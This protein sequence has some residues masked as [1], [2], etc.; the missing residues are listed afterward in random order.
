MA[1]GMVTQMRPTM[2]RM[3]LR[4]RVMVLLS[5]PLAACYPLRLPL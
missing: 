5:I 3:R 4:D 1:V 2:R